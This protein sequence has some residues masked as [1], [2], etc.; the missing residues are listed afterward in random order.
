MFKFKLT[1]FLKFLIGFFNISNLSLFLL[2]FDTMKVYCLYVYIKILLSLLEHMPH[3]ISTQHTQ[4]IFY[5]TSISENFLWI[6]YEIHFLRNGG[7]HFS[8]MNDEDVPF[9]HT[10]LA[11]PC[12]NYSLF[13]IISS[14]IRSSK[15]S[16]S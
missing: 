9:Q 8:Q 3:I 6:S 15:S 4:I 10:F 14:K 12:Q 1:I 16:K 11:G 13:K 7:I 5:T 2:R